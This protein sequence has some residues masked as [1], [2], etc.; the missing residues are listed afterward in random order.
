VNTA[1]NTA[2]A[3]THDFK[4]IAGSVVTFGLAG[5]ET[6]DVQATPDGVNYT[7]IYTLDATTPS[8]SIQSPSTLRLVKAATAGVVVVGIS[9]ASNT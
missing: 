5:A 9:T 1:I 4:L 2:A 7:T 8:C 3:A 6:V